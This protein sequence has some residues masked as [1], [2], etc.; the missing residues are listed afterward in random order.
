MVRM[1]LKNVEKSIQ[2]HVVRMHYK[3]Q[4][5]NMNLNGQRPLFFLSHDMATL[6]HI[7]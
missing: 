5:M 2:S 7:F 4:D 3:I 6:Q 1:S